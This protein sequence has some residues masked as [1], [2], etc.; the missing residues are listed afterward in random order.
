MKRFMI[1]GKTGCGKTSLLQRLQGQ[2][3]VYQKTQTVE[4]FETLIDTPGE[5]LEQKN[6]YS[7]LIVTATDCDELILLQ[8]ADD[9][10]SSFPPNL[11]ACFNR[12][13][14]GVVT[15]VDLTD[16][17]EARNAA[18]KCLMEAGASRIFFVSAK[19]GAGVDELRS[20]LFENEEPGVSG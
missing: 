20:F 16:H 11:D 17:A 4:F 3:M 13:V 14:T 8:A 1:I 10:D 2:E 18:E 6:L 9:E 19:T 7:A 5:Y 12:L 15:K